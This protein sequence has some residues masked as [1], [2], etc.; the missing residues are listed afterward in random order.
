[1][2][3]AL[4]GL[5][6]ISA[7]EVK[8]WTL[9]DCIEYALEKNIQLQQSQIAGRESEVDVRSARAALFPNLSFSTGQN[10]TNRPY[11]EKSSTVSGT[12][13]ISSNNKTTYNGSYGLNAQWTLWDGNQRR[14]TLKQKKASRQIAELEVAHTANSLQEQIAQLYIQVL[15]A[16][17]SVKVNRQT[18]EVSQATFERGKVLFQEGNLSKANCAQLEAQVGNDHYQLVTAENA[19]RNYRLQLK[20]LLE[21]EPDV[22]LELVLPADTDGEVLQPLPSCQEVYQQALALRP[23]IQSSKLQR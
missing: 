23:E 4:V 14:N 1:M 3:E 18:L 17:E 12:E 15:Y 2:I 8:K 13:I 7:Q 9:N 5:T 6:S 16:E 20:Q 10:V 19:L 22:E 11:Q 21:L